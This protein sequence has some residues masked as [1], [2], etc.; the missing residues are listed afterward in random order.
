MRYCTNKA[1]AKVTIYR[2]N[3]SPLIIV[4]DNP[5][6]EVLME[7]L[8]PSNQIYTLHYQ[9]RLISGGWQDY[10]VDYRYNSSVSQGYSPLLISKDGGVVPI[11]GSSTGANNKD[12]A[13]KLAVRNPAVGTFSG[14]RIIIRPDNDAWLVVDWTYPAGLVSSFPTCQ[15]T[16][17]DSIRTI[18]QGTL[19]GKCPYY[20]VECDDECPEGHC[21]CDSP[22]YPGY[23]C[24]PCKPTAQR[25]SNLAGKIQL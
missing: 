17:N 2:N 18:Y 1:K 13:D 6:V 11:I 22:D 16:V 23:C 15:I 7:E 8:P 21:K 4:S 25:I 5:P 3:N 14:N 20:T 9:Y 10:S 24:L 19:D 12:E